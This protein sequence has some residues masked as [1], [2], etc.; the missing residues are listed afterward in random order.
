MSDSDYTNGYDGYDGSYGDDGSVITLPF[1]S[2]PND[3]RYVAASDRRMLYRDLWSNMV[4]KQFIFSQTDTNTF[5]FSGVVLVDGAYARYTGHSVTLAPA[6]PGAR[7]IVA[8]IMNFN[9]RQDIGFRFASNEPQDIGHALIVAT[10]NPQGA[11]WNAVG[12]TPSPI[13]IP[14]GTVTGDRLRNQ[15]IGRAQ[16]ANNAIGRNQIQNNEVLNQH[17]ANVAASKITGRITD[18]QSR[19][20]FGMFH[21]WVTI[22]ANA[23]ESP[24]TTLVPS[25]N[26]APMGVW[27]NHAES[28]AFSD[29][30]PSLA[31]IQ[32]APW[33][34]PVY[35]LRAARR[36][37]RTTS[38][39]VQ[40]SIMWSFRH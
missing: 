35:N 1:D 22:A 27:V 26:A 30:W 40:I 37:R 31:L 5:T 15:T 36:E 14:P 24:P 34:S 25:A 4:I 9:G 39:R 18:A 33:A 12:V 6:P 21:Y 11:A 3:E 10:L 32:G 23:F 19:F 13:R 38:S 8:E 29:H 7:Y 2:S 20:T 17:I 16:I 28:H